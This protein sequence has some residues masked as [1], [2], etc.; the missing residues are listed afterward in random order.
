MSDK[1]K[2]MLPDSAQKKTKVIV[3]D[4][5]V[6]RQYITYKNGKWVLLFG[7]VITFA[8]VVLS[9]L[10]F[11]ALQLTAT[12]LLLNIV[13]WGF[14]T[15]P[16]VHNGLEM[17]FWIK[18]T[19]RGHDEGL[20]WIPWFLLSRLVVFDM[21]KFTID[22]PEEDNYSLGDWHVWYDVYFSCGVRP[23]TSAGFVNNLLMSFVRAFQKKP[24]TAT[25][26]YN[27]LSNINMLEA[28][29]ILIPTASEEIRNAIN[30][31]S[32]DDIFHE[33][34]ANDER[35]DASLDMQVKQKIQNEVLPIFDRAARDF[36]LKIYDIRLS[37]VDL[38][39]RSAEIIQ[40][41]RIAEVR[42]EAVTIIYT[43]V[44][45]VAEQLN[46]RGPHIAETALKLK[47]IEAIKTAGE[48]GG[49]LGTLLQG[50][51]A[52]NIGQLTGIENESPIISKVEV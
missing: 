12:I 52:T 20:I 23:V 38:H 18:R 36:G 33:G 9:Q 14:R 34:A 37:D 15:I 43:A 40:E 41:R 21:V 8:T 11:H 27:Y 42:G 48:K 2:P 26:L 6:N 31:R 50:I 17:R 13:G 10:F 1:G 44:Q 3:S 30:K 5:I 46:A 45:K 4:E 39:A 49:L 24:T 7:Y 22:V 35:V 51:N 25:G 32:F 19:K 47:I 29:R 28:L 16:A